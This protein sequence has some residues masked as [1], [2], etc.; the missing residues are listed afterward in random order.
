MPGAAA[1]LGVD[2]EIV[3]AAKEAG[4]EA[5]R[6][7]GGVNCD[8]LLQWLS[9]HP[10]VGAA[11]GVINKVLEEALKIRADRQTKEHKLAEM[12]RRGTDTPGRP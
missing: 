2:P 12:K 4:C 5:F 6:A 10:E 7:R 11:T 8:V 9:E 3:S 1:I